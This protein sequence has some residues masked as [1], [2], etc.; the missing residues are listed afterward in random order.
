MCWKHFQHRGEIIQQLSASA[1]SKISPP[2]A[3]ADEGLRRPV[4]CSVGG[5]VSRAVVGEVRTRGVVS[6]T[7]PVLEAVRHT[8]EGAGAVPVVRAVA[9]VGSNSIVTVAGARGVA[10]TLGR[11]SF[12]NTYNNSRCN[13]LLVVEVGVDVAVSVGVAVAVGGVVAVVRAEPVHV[14][15]ARP[16]GRVNLVVVLL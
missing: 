9:G 2:E 13:N 14:H 1:I 4:T 3:T 10:V 15:R 5:P 7:H 11:G 8:Q 12:N 6:H 16:G